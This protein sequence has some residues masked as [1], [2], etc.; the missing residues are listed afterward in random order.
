MEHHMSWKIHL[1]EKWRRAQECRIKSRT[2]VREK[3]N[4]LPRIGLYWKGECGEGCN[5]KESVAMKS[6]VLQWK[7]EG[8]NEKERVL[9]KR[10]EY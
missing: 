1:L 6:R 10:S 3:L 7:G 5:Q 8:Y 4:Y 9:L 2:N